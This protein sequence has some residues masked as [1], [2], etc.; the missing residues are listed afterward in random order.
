MARDDA[1]SAASSHASRIGVTLLAK[2]YELLDA[3]QLR[4]QRARVRIRTLGSII[5]S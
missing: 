4:A 2:R 3:A 1:R 5:E